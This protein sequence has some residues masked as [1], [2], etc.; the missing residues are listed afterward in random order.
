MSEEIVERVDRSQQLPEAAWQVIGENGFRT[1]RIAD[2]ATR[3]GVSTGTVHYYFPTKRDLLL[4]AFKYNIDQSAARRVDV[5]EKAQNPLDQ[6]R[7]FVES[8]LPISDETII[9]WRLWTEF[10]A[11]GLHDA[12]IQTMNDLSYGAWRDLI[13]SL[14]SA[15]QRDNRIRPGDPASMANCLVAV[16]DGLAM[17][18]VLNSSRVN[19]SIMRYTCFSL[20]D[21]WTTETQMPSVV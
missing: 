9:T 20:L 5:Y 3:V 7:A 12:T 11:E 14:I 2:V 4:A 19:A 18:V 17:Q 1:V 8:Y 16:M 21:S 10:W 13:E 6:L 15:A